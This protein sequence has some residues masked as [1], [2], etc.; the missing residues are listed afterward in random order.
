MNTA[1]L[2]PHNAT[3]AD[4]PGIEE[5]PLAERGLP[6]STRARRPYDSFFNL[7]ERYGSTGARSVCA[8][9]RVCHSA[10]TAVRCTLDWGTSGHRAF[11]NKRSACAAAR[12]AQLN[13]RRPRRVISLLRRHSRKGLTSPL[14]YR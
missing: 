3:L 4:L 13:Q 5:V 1:Q 2:W 10:D 12:S 11:H 8:H 6:T 7:K 9:Q 14:P